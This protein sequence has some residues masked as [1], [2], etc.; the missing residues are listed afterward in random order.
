MRT[1]IATVA[2]AFLAL[3][4]YLFTY[5]YCDLTEL[6]FE[7]VYPGI[8]VLFDAVILVQLVCVYLILR[9]LR[10]K[11]ETWEEPLSEEKKG[12]PVSLNEKD[13]KLLS[14]I[15]MICVPVFVLLLFHA[16]FFIFI[17]GKW[18]EDPYLLIYSAYFIASVLILIQAIGTSVILKA[19][20]REKRKSKS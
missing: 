10:K 20:E 14:R 18:S 9:S 16:A 7:N 5:A 17:G 13:K 11:R 19:I 1:I 15:A 4:L 8:L 12:Q 3:I 2:A 6:S